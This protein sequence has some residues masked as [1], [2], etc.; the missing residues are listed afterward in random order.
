MI[1][2]NEI[3]FIF[4]LIGGTEGIFLTIWGLFSKSKICFSG[5]IL[6]FAINIF[7]QATSLLSGTD[8]A[9]IGIILGLFIIAIVIVIERTKIHLLVQRQR[10][11]EY[12]EGWDW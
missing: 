7:Y 5:G 11:R 6:T 2:T 8:G 10:F 1:T 4:V 9:I 12:I 3:E